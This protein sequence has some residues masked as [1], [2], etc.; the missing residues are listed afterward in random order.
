MCIAGVAG[1]DCGI[2][3]LAIHIEAKSLIATAVCSLL[4]IL[5]YNKMIVP[6]SN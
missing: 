2:H 3:Q 5:H 1:V 4:A 6:E